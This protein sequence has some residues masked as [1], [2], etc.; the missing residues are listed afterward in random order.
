[1]LSY[2]HYAVA[3]KILIHVKI[4]LSNLIFLEILYFIADLLYIFTKV[5][6]AQNSYLNK[7]FFD[8]IG[9]KHA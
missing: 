3:M 8:W 4:L 5:E 7:N 6:K 1:M 2:A 9:I